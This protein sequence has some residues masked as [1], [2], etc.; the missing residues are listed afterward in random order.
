MD[1]SKFWCVLWNPTR[2]HI[3]R[4]RLD[5]YIKS[6]HGKFR[7]GFDS[8]DAEVLLEISDS[9]EELD[10]MLKKWADILLEK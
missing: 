7:E 5:Y 6:V 2:R 8:R 10:I 1:N 3:Q 9:S 4:E